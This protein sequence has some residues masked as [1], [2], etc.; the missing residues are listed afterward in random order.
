MRES[1]EVCVSL[2]PA[3]VGTDEDDRKQREKKQSR[4]FVPHHGA[5][6]VAQMVAREQDFLVQVG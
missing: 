6:M 5:A 3:I 2:S 1:K 4:W